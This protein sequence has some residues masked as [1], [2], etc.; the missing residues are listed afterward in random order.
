MGGGG[1]TISF[2]DDMVAMVP[3]P[4]MTVPVR[5]ITLNLPADHWY[6]P[7]SGNPLGLLKVSRVAVKT[8]SP[9][10]LMWIWL[11]AISLTVARCPPP[12]MASPGRATELSTPFE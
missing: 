5:A 2:G 6:R 3:T 11:R 7:V 10:L 9:L 8:M 4:G 1:N 12:G